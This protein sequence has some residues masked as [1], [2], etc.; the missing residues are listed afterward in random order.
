M[1]EQL[2]LCNIQQHL[3]LNYFANHVDNDFDLRI[4]GPERARRVL[5]LLG[6]HVM[7]VAHVDRGGQ[8]RHGVLVVGHAPGRDLAVREGV[9]GRVLPVT[10]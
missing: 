8:V 9:V 2:I 4:A 3:V 1:F 10:R 6:A 7:E 5:V